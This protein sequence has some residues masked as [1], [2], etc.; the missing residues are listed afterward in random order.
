MIAARCHRS[1]NNGAARR[2]AGP[3][4]QRPMDK[5]SDPTVQALTVKFDDAEVFSAALK[6]V[7]M[8]VVQTGKG[9]FRAIYS[10][11]TTGACDVQMGSISQPI[12][13]RGASDPKRIGLLVELRKSRDWS[14]F[15]EPMGDTG[16]AVCSG[17][18]EMLLRAAPGTGW[19]FISAPPET[20]A[21]CAHSAYGRELRLPRG[22]TRIKPDLLELA[23]I[24]DLLAESISALRAGNPNPTRV[25]SSIDRAWVR[26]IVQILLGETSPIPS[27]EILRVRRVLSRV[28]YF[29]A[30][31][32]EDAIHVEDLCKA[33]GVRRENLVSIFRNYVG[34]D[35]IQ[36]L[37]IRR[38]N[39]VHKALRRGDPATTS[40]ANVA[41]A[42][43]F[44][45]LG[46]FT[47]QFTELFGEAP[48][49]VL[50]ATPR[51]LS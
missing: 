43:G 11:F 45:H 21:Q 13:A 20:L 48:L 9:V 42:W 49:K 51:L 3:W 31:H 19:A 4:N 33:T 36:Y 28:H 1:E 14:W 32:L 24:R 41:R 2:D 38:L 10:S 23:V 47:R 27:A 44:S 8:E 29:M 12:F 40:I 34:L 39:Q 16:V 17:G 6:E 30:A 7:D 15:G 22:P 5:P 25:I 46:A 37:K 26:S 35:P 18:C 50:Q